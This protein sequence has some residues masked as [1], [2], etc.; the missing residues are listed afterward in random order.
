MTTSPDA[1]PVFELPYDY[2]GSTFVQE[3][4]DNQLPGGKISSYFDHQYP[5]YC[6]P[7][8]SNGCTPDDLHAVNFYGYDGGNLSSNQPP[9]NVTY[10]GHDGIDFALSGSPDVLAAASG[11]VLNFDWD[12]CTGNWVEI[13][14]ANGYVT[15]YYHLASFAQGLTKGQNVY[16]ES[17]DDPRA[18]IGVMG[19]TGTCAMNKPHIHFMILNKAK[20]KLSDISY[21][22]TCK[23]QN[24]EN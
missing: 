15:K 1:F 18:I 23:K 10:N 13:Q 17:I 22:E 3:S 21:L 20:K 2:T 11:F 4:T 9:Y 24:I 7:P 14:H 5:T 12:N 19:G 6:E 8:N 16:R